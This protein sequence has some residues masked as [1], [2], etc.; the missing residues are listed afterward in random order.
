MVTM[1][2]KTDGVMQE[3]VGSSGTKDRMSTNP[4]VVNVRPPIN[5]LDT[6]CHIQL[7]A[8]LHPYNVIKSLDSQ[9]TSQD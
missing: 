6:V 1:H 9:E 2:G 8:S 3:S 7:A 5:M 4:K